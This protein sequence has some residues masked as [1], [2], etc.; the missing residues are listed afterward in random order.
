M[1]YAHQCLVKT[2]SLITIGAMLAVPLPAMAVKIHGAQAGH[3]VALGNR[4]YV[5]RTFWTDRTLV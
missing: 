1:K 4:V 3:N 2:S 5:V